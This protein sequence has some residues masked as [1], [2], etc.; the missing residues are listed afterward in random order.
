M[1]EDPAYTSLEIDCKQ[2]RRCIQI[3]LIC[4]NPERTK[5]PAVNKI[6]NM[7]H[8]LESMNWYISNEVTSLATHT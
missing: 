4:V 7:L 6:I 3:G 1:Q 8:G 5:R 2:I